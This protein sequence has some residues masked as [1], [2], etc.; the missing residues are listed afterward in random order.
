MALTGL[1]AGR[2]WHA[3][4]D[5]VDLYDAKGLAE[6][7]LVT[8]GAPGAVTQPWASGEEPGYLEPGRAARLLIDGEEVAR[9]GEVAHRVRE[10]FDLAAPAFVAE[11]SLSALV[12]RT[13]AVPRY[14]PLPRF[15][16]VQRDLALVVSDDVTVAQVESAIRGLA[17]PWLVEI[18][19]FD[20]YSGSQVGAGKRSLAWSLTYQAPDRTLT[21]A[22]V[23]GAHARL[24][25]ELAARFGAEVRGA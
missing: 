16:A 6:L 19:L 14:A 12:A 22:E 2:A 23:N 21:D 13:A 5:R 20:V 8:A 1:R 24:V 7:A 18:A 4:R 25:R 10:V 15:P 9:F 11:V 3:S 17:V